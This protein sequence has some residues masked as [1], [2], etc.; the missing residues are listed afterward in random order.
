MKW[1]YLGSGDRERSILTW[2]SSVY[3][4]LCLSGGPLASWA[5]SLTS[6]WVSH[7]CTLHCCSNVQVLPGQGRQEVRAGRGFAGSLFKHPALSQI[8]EKLPLIQASPETSE[9]DVDLLH[10]ETFMPLLSIPCH[11]P[12]IP[13][14]VCHLKSV[15]KGRGSRCEIYMTG[16]PFIWV[17]MCDRCMRQHGWCQWTLPN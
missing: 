17:R 5:K 14:L 15:I 10:G 1:P 16:M 6:L 3:L 9:I 8:S 7:W 12:H 13:L 4:L 2:H 11:K